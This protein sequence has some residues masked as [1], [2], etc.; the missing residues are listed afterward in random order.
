MLSPVPKSPPRSTFFR[1]IRSL[2]RPQ[3]MPLR[4]SAK[5]NEDVTMPTYMPIRVLSVEIWKSSTMKYAY[6]KIDMNAIGSQIRQSAKLLATSE[7][8]TWTSSQEL[9]KYG[10][11]PCWKRCFVSAIG[12]HTTESSHCVVIER[13]RSLLAKIWVEATIVG[14]RADLKKSKLSEKNTCATCDSLVSLK[15]W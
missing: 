5:A 15:A 8:T 2:R 7:T 11:L 13:D 9:T 6:G 4:H 12:S 14:G 1:P 3:K 10:H